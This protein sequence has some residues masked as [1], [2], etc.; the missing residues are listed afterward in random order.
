MQSSGV[1]QYGQGDVTFVSNPANIEVYQ[2]RAKPGTVFVEFNVPSN[3]LY[4]ADF[5]NSSL[6]PASYSLYGMRMAKVGRGP[7]DDVPATNI[8]IV[9]RK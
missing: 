5:P 3:S 4:P 6:I 1:V 9:G 2:S 8:E 7:Y